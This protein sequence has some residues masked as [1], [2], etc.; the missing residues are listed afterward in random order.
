MLSINWPV[1][2]KKAPGSDEAA[3]ARR[4]RATHGQSFIRAKCDFMRS[5]DLDKGH[6]S[7]ARSQSEFSNTMRLDRICRD[8]SKPSG[9]EVLEGFDNLGLS[10]HDEG[11]VGHNGLAQWLATDDEEF[12]VRRT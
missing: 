2:I 4:Q 9:L 11:S 8:D 1:M 3:G 12:E 10:A 6:A 7:P 5:D